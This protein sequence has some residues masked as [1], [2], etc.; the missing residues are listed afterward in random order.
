[1][2]ELQIER[3]PIVSLA[4]QEEIVFVPGRRDPV[5]LE[6]Q[7]PALHLIQRIRDEAHRFAVGYHRVRRSQ[8][9]RTGRGSVLDT[10]EG[11]GDARRR[12]LLTFFGSPE[13]VVSA[14]L[15]EI[16]AVPG[17]PGKVARRIHEQLHRLGG[18]SIIDESNQ[19]PE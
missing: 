7:S 8:D 9:A 5:V 13:R 16:E 19:I 14:S 18:T 10:L 17:L 4:K 1:M 15:E 6:R 2:R 3:V 11:V 12:A